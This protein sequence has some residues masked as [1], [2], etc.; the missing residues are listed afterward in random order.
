MDEKVNKVLAFVKDK[1]KITTEKLKGIRTLGN[2]LA[3]CK[4]EMISKIL[5]R[6]LMRILSKSLRQMARY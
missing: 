3:K 1:V 5:D 6:K 4:S 2:K